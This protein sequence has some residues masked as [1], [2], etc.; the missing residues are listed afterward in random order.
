MSDSLKE[1]ES[2]AAGAGQGRVAAPIT[3]DTSCDQAQAL[4]AWLAVQR[5]DNTRRAYLTAWQDFVAFVSKSVWQVSRADVIAWSKKMQEAGASP[6]TIAQRLA[7]VS[8]FYAHC[9]ARFSVPLLNPVIGVRRPSLSP[10]GKSSYLSAEQLRA[11]L[12][13]IPRN[14]T[15]GLRDYALILMHIATGQHTAD[16]TALS[17]FFAP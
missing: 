7:A 10:Y 12:K 15:Q 5:S 9:A 3:H 6:A 16:I 17:L 11:L 8:S 4:E 2:L 13:M 1:T 14:S